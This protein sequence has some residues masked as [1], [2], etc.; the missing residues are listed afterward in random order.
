MKD[1]KW[2]ISL[3]A[4]LILLAIGY[5]T[6]S[7]SATKAGGA[8]VV[9]SGI[10]KISQE[11]PKPDIKIVHDT[12]RVPR[13]V[14]KT[15]V[16]KVEVKGDTETIYVN[17][18]IVPS[19]FVD[20]IENDHGKFFLEILQMDG[21]VAGWDLHIEPNTSKLEQT[22]T[23][24]TNGIRERNEA[25]IRDYLIDLNRPKREGWVTV[26]P[27]YNFLSGNYQTAVGYQVR[28]KRL[29]FGPSISFDKEGVNHAGGTLGFKLFEKKK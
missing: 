19:V 13:F 5:L 24:V 10:S 8:L 6:K 22:V 16:E 17:Q 27:G 9:N 20:S 1:Y 2:I 11:A 28:G 15:I 4:G 26:E 21:H 3:V 7:D 25:A 29:S 18:D 23:E 14:Y 12:I